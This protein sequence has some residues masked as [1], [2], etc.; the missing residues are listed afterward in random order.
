MEQTVTGLQWF[1]AGLVSGCGFGCTAGASTL[2]SVEAWYQN[3][4]ERPG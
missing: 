4:W 3:M 2:L 1:R